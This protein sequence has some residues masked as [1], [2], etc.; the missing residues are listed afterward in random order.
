MN[1]GSTGMTSRL[2]LDVFYQTQRTRPWGTPHTVMV[3]SHDCS[4]EGSQ[5]AHQ[6]ILNAWLNPLKAALKGILFN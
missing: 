5:Q 6:L 2:P 3:S 1:Y 4:V